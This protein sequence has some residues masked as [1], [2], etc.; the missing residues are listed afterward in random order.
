L[1]GLRRGGN[2]NE[3]VPDARDQIHPDVAIGDGN[4]FH[5]DGMMLRDVQAPVTEMRESRAQVK[6]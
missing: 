2:A 6:A 4:Q 3:L 5:R 1:A